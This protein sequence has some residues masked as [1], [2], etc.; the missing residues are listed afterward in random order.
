MR[1][2][3]PMARKSKYTPE[4]VNTLFGAL[5]TGMT[6]GD[7]CLVAGIDEATFYRWQQTK[8]EF[9][10]R[11]LRARER[12][13][14][15]DLLIIKQAGKKGDWRAAAEHLDRTRSPYRKSVDLA[16]T[17]T[18]RHDHRHWTVDDLTDEEIEALLPLAKRA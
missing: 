5:Q 9:R 12:G 16:I 3:C 13:W 17:G 6:D 10:D 14:L 8:S 15:E 1:I 4:L 7:A 11:V 2:P 18:V